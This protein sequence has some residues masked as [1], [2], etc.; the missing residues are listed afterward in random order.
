MRSLLT[1]ID[2][3]RLDLR[4]AIRS[5]RR[6]PGFTVLAVC[7]LGIGI[8]ATTAGFSLLNRLFLQ[9]LPG[10]R[11]PNRLAFVTFMQPA[12]G[13]F[14]ARGYSSPASPMPE[15]V[16]QVL[17]ASP[18]VVG[19]AGW[20]GTMPMN[21]GVTGQLA[22][23]VEGSFVT[24]NYLQLLGADAQRGRILLP[25]DDPQ[26]MGTRVAVISDR[27]WNELYDRRSDVI[28]STII[29]NN[30]PFTLVG[31]TARGFRGPDRISPCDLWVPG[32][33]YWDV[34]H[35]PTQ[36]HPPIEIAYYRN[37]IR[38]RPGA[39]FDQAQAQLEGAM[40]AVAVT[41]T[42]HFGGKVTA[43][44]VPGVGMERGGEAVRHELLLIMAVAGLVLFVACANIA[45]LLLFRRTQRR[46]D[47][48]VRLSLGA[49]RGR[50]V[51]LFLTESALV[52][53]AGGVTGILIALGLR[54]AFGAMKILGFL[55]VGPVP[56]DARVVGF[57]VGLGLVAALLAGVAP[58]L[59]GTAVDLNADLKAS[60]PNQSGGAPRLRLGLSTAQIAISL[61]LVAGMYLLAAT[62][63]NYARI[64]LGFQPEGVTIFQTDPNEAGYDIAH[65]RSYYDLMSRRIGSLPGVTQVAL[66]DLPPFT[67]VSFGIS[68]RAGA[69]SLSANTVHVSPGYF[70]TLGIP[71]LRGTSF[72]ESDLW[73]DTLNPMKKIVL[74]LSVSRS[75]F[76]DRDPIGQ[77]ID[78]PERRDLFRAMVVGVVGDVRN[79]FIGPPD[80]M[81]YQP[82]GD[83]P[84]LYSPSIMIKSRESIAALT[85]SVREVARGV[86]GSVTVESRGALPE[87]VAASINT[88]HLFFRVL[89]ALSLL[90]MI[91]TA[92][93]VYGVVAYG[94]TTRTR[95]FGIRTALGAIPAN[96]VQAA[97]RPAFTIILVGTIAGIL[98]ALY[99]TKFIAASLYGVSR[100]DPLA[101][102]TA[103]LI[104]AL[105]VLVASWLPARR[106]AKIDPMVAL[107]YE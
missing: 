50:L 58:A 9:P 33:T 38:L 47:I 79:D 16:P 81:V 49:G 3:L 73:P 54:A 75:L 83:W 17:K 86:D 87:T 96:L 44:L 51:R 45:N 12:G 31:V 57:A 77:V 46:T 34:R 94:V 22:A 100:L 36:G 27:L 98:G 25:E 42:A 56:L 93:G 13:A 14:G 90:T 69:E 61:T 74:S 41:D 32:N 19:L 68:L 20:Q 7:T 85:K 107:R 97:L 64:P 99:L 2:T 26:P 60:A 66:I 101:F 70:A 18:A 63:R 78:V 28:G 65:T 103:A 95:E 105:A 11:D 106:A 10:V 6:S 24:G 21:V 55:D 40:Q 48:V 15:E 5:L 72:A 62:L 4:Y 104:L 76:G 37:V 91:L 39:S 59:L 80:R 67:H 102:V 35:F 71:I 23:R 29:I 88:Q 52:G 43:T 92:V 1:M 8:G 53:L 30:L 89:G 84:R 82:V